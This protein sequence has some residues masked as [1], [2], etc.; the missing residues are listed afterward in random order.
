M[1]KIFDFM[2]NIYKKQ[3][4]Y[5]ATRATLIKLILALLLCFTIFL[6]IYFLLNYNFPLRK[7]S[8]DSYGQ[9]GII[10]AL[11]LIFENN[12]QESNLFPSLLRTDPHI[13]LAFIGMSIMH[14][15]LELP[16]E[17]IL[18]IFGI[19]NI[20]F[21]Y[22]SIYILVH[23]ITKNKRITILSFILIAILPNLNPTHFS[24]G[25]S[26]FS[27][28]DIVV[29][30]AYP[31]TFAA[32]LLF[33]LLWLT[34]RNL[35]RKYLDKKYLFLQLSF[36]FTLITAHFLTAIIYF[37]IIVLMIFCKLVFEKEKNDINSKYFIA[38]L[39]TILIA[40]IFAYF[41]PFYNLWKLLSATFSFFQES[42]IASGSEDQA[43]YSLAS[44]LNVLSISILGVI[45]LM[46][47]NRRFL[48]V[49]TIVFLL[50]NSSFL[51][52]LPLKIPMYWRFAPWTKIPLS[53]GLAYLLS[54][55][56]EKM[57]KIA[58]ILFSI[59]IVISFVGTIENINL[60]T[61]VEDATKTYS[62]LNGLIDKNA[63]MLAD[64][65][66][67]YVIQGLYGYSTVAIPTGHVT[68]PE[69]LLEDSKRIAEVNN[70]LNNSS[71]G[72]EWNFLIEKYEIDYILLNKNKNILRDR[73][74]FY[75]YQ[76]ILKFINGTVEYSNSYFVLIKVHS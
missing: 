69:V 50:I 71:D 70:I 22:F 5:C 13:S 6:F 14:I 27:I 42:P 39:L 31:Q 57:K 12:N 55:L 4:L 46:K 35:N 21:L 68:N 34:I 32:G 26:L 25:G 33:F 18:L 76:T 19:F 15:S 60:L 58:P 66:D 20:L 37:L 2:F 67:S 49:W 24:I 56:D 74:L 45:S 41:W 65:F 51:I 61:P 73:N 11:D 17:N 52:S 3:K 38:S 64:P 75:N 8:F 30:A 28:S 23:E 63:T 1:S 7:S 48:F 43:Y 40:L 53:I 10:R 59:I 9:L 44:I 47:K 36:M 16:I 62:F 72:K 29:I 54:D